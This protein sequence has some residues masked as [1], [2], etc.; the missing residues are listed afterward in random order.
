MS[1]LLTASGERWRRLWR[2]MSGAEAMT[3]AGNPSCCCRQI[4][5]RQALLG[6]VMSLVAGSADADC[7]SFA[8]VDRI[9]GMKFYADQSGSV[10][11]KEA[12]QRNEELQ[13]PVRKMLEYVEKSLDATEGK[14]P[15]TD[16]AFNIIGEWARRR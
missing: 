9:E 8:V 14:S 16:C 2:R 15:T 12:Q 5:G 13:E 11:D 10:V 7:P 3:S 6:L 4:T 1:P